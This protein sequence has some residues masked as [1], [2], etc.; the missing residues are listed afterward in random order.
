METDDS[1]HYCIRIHNSSLPPV[2]QGHTHFTIVFLCIEAAEKVLTVMSSLRINS[3]VLTPGVIWVCVCEHWVPC[4]I[5]AASPRSKNCVAPLLRHAVGLI[6]FG[7]SCLFLVTLINMFLIVQRPLSVDCV[8]GVAYG[9]LTC[10]ALLLYMHVVSSS[11]KICS[12][13]VND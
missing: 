10:V 7:F 11:K 5:V 1:E 3:V 12:G 6:G 4:G 9:C 8:A 2:F 13:K